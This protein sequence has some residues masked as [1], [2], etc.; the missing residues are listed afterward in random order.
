MQIDRVLS[1]DSGNGL[2]RLREF[3]WMFWKWNAFS[4]MLAPVELPD[5]AGVTAQIIDDPERIAEVNPFAPVMLSNS[6]AMFEEFLRS[7]PG[8][9][10][11]TILRPCE[12]S[13]LIEQKKRNRITFA[14]PTVDRSTDELVVLVGVDCPGTYPKEQYN[15]RVIDSGI[16]SITN[17]AL[18]YGGDGGLL[19]NQLRLACQLCDSPVPKGADITIGFLGVAPHHYISITPRDQFID[20]LLNLE[21]STDQIASEHHVQNRQAIIRAIKKECA[22]RRNQLMVGKTWKIGDL[23]NLLACSARC[24]LCADCLDAC[25]LYKGELS[26][27]LGV[28]TSQQRQQPLLL[29]FVTLSRWLAACSGCGMCQEA[30]E[31]GVSLFPLIY[32]L[33]HR[34][35]EEL[36]YPVGD[37][38][39]QLPWE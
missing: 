7:Y 39:E 19:R 4:A 2:N 3:L 37:P 9:R 11:I 32:V 8:G 20:N 24:T 34:I 12:L 5:G 25:P 33:S 10:L 22:S 29:E 17:E 13:T 18:L 26:G 14:S 36:N 38:L 6:T 35:R 27:M 1:F 28:G 23:C 30:C 21:E 31:H 16:E 15:Q